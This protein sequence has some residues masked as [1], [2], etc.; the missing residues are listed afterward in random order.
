MLAFTSLL[1][2][3]RMF[4]ITRGSFGHRTFF[5]AKIREQVWNIKSYITAVL[6]REDRTHSTAALESTDV[7]LSV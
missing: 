7:Q 4:K 3:R 2:P 1:K 5:P 6:L